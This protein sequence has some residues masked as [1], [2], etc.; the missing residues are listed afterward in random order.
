MHWPATRETLRFSLLLFL[1]ILLLEVSRPFGLSTLV[2]SPVT[3]AAFFL[4]GAIALGIATLLGL[5]AGLMT[6]GE[7]PADDARG[8]VAGALAG[9]L[10]FVLL[11]D[12]MQR[13][14]MDRD[15]APHIGSLLALGVAALLAG[16]SAWILSG[17]IP[18][19][20]R[21]YIAVGAGVLL[22]VAWIAVVFKTFSPESNLAHFVTLRVG[23][24]VAAVLLVMAG[25]QRLQGIGATS[26][27]FGLA[28]LVPLVCIAIV[29]TTGAGAAREPQ[30]TA[31]SP[32]GRPNVLLVIVD[33]LRAD[34]TGL[35][36]FSADHTPRLAERVTGRGTRF[37][38][39]WSA[40]P[41]TIPSMK[42]LFTGQLSSHFGGED[43]IVQ[44]PPASATTLA[45]AL[46]DAGY[47]TLGITANG[48]VS[49]EGFEQGFASYHNVA[50]HDQFVRSFFLNHVLAGKRVYRGFA[51]MERLRLH[52]ERSDAVTRLA[53]DRIE[54][55]HTNEDRPFFLYLH[56]L[57]P[58]WPY[59]A[60]GMGAVPEALSDLDEPFSHI[61]FLRLPPPHP[62]HAEYARDPRMQEMKGRYNDEIRAADRD[63]DALL[64]RLDAAGLLDSSLIVL[65]GDHGEEFFEH[66]AFGHGQ[67]VYVEQLHVPLVFLWPQGAK[68]D[69]MPREIEAPVSLVDVLPTLTELLEIELDEPDALL[70]R[71]L[72]PLLEGRATPRPPLVAESRDARGLRLIWRDGRHV[73]RFAYTTSGGALEAE[74]IR[75]FDQQADPEQLAPLD[76]SEPAVQQ[77]VE[78]AQRDIRARGLR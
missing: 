6:A 23:W 39:A 43:Q 18:R 8:G 66:W 42:S 47:Q 15:L 69:A 4:A 72:V 76:A 28:L 17:A 68:Y 34:H 12:A 49:G 61:D 45:E 38:Q 65:A 32:R 57:D 48:L 14:A 73:V 78:R 31:P 30:T 35:A 70:G 22:L 64:T 26:A 53:A 24:G 71:S 74:E 75:V 5:A 77:I 29:D 36:G 16:L 40:A 1:P 11:L 13:F 62:D 51:W 2:E 21:G 20:L 41:N 25:R 44:R 7:E 67:D 50:S 10:A 33:T 37:T 54:E 59:H 9:A 63:L 19:S 55:A 3:R 56:L 27:A 46:R 52:K 60:R 58:H